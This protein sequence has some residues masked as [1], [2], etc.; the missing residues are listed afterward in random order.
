MLTLPGSQHAI[1]RTVSILVGV[2]V[3][4]GRNPIKLIVTRQCVDK[5]TEHSEDAAWTCPRC[6]KTL[7]L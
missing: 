1:H 3:A 6:T 5:W 7:P 2:E 4:M